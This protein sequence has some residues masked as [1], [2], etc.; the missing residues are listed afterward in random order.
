[1][2]LW[3][4]VEKRFSPKDH[5]LYRVIIAPING[6]YGL[7]GK[8]TGQGDDKMMNKHIFYQAYF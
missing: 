7:A 2:V 5:F 4:I 3:V 6:V 8:N 1:M